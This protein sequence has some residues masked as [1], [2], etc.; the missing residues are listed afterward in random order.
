M[1]STPTHNDS[2]FALHNGGAIIAENGILEINAAIDAQIPGAED[3][4]GLMEIEG[5]NATLK[6]DAGFNGAASIQN[7]TIQFNNDGANEQL[8]IDGSEIDGSNIGVSIANFAVGDSIDLTGIQADGYT[9]NSSTHELDLTLQ[10]NLVGSLTLTDLPRGAQFNVIDDS[11]GHG[12]LITEKPIVNIT[13]YASDGIDFQDLPNPLSEMGS[14]TV[15]PGGNKTFTIDG[16]GSQPNFVVDGYG[17][18]YD[19]NGNI[20]GGTITAIHD[21]GTDGSPIADFTGNFDA[22]QWMSGVQQIATSGDFTAIN[23]MVANYDFDFL[24]SAGPDSFGGAGHNQNMSGGAGNDVFDPNNHNPGD[25]R[26]VTLTGGSGADTFVYK[27]GAGA[28]TITDFDQGNSGGFSPTEGDQIEL[29]G[30]SNPV[31]LQQVG[32]N[33]IADFG[34]GDVLTF[35]NMTPAQV[36]SISSVVQPPANGVSYGGPGTLILDTSSAQSF[37]IAGTAISTGSGAGV[38]LGTGDT[39]AADTFLLYIDAASS[40]S[41]TATGAAGININSS[42]ASVDLVNNATCRRHPTPTVPSA[43]MSARTGPATLR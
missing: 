10:G 2:T 16:G 27:V 34:N 15:Q 6:I 7:Q 23:T 17:F 1:I 39:N 36:Q 4:V 29:E 33:T 22:A 37:K 9:Y 20:T 14:G 5:A 32:S 13:V 38:V 28:V 3:P 24:G 42:G 35:L 12:T 26:T 43:S 40:V 19:I 31:S 30:L 41:T 18:T 11:S 21:I 8:V 25:P